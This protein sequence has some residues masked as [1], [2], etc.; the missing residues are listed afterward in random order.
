L[1]HNY[2]WMDEILIWDFLIFFKVAC[3]KISYVQKENQLNHES[4]QEMKIKS[5]VVRSSKIVLKLIEEGRSINY[6]C[7]AY[8][9]NR[10]MQDRHSYQF[11]LATSIQEQ[12]YAVY[13]TFQVLISF[14]DCL[15]CHFSISLSEEMVGL[16]DFLFVRSSFLGVR[17]WKNIKKSDIKIFSLVPYSN[18]YKVELP[19]TARLRPQNA[20]WQSLLISS[21]R[22]ATVTIDVLIKWTPDP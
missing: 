9:L 22:G 12:K 10:S 21:A 18:P 2:D 14:S 7:L 4:L 11:D 6:T 15:K 20:I 17:Q 3:L 13:C 19:G 5:D 1:H 16:F 8:F